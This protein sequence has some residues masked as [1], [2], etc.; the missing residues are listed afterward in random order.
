MRG[1]NISINGPILLEE[2]YESAKVLQQ[3]YSIERTFERLGFL[4]FNL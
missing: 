4:S 2:A 3:F 1:N